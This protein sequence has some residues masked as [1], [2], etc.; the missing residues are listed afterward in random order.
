M[1]TSWRIDETYVRTKG[2]WKYLYRAV[3]KAGHTVDFLLTPQQ[4]RAAAAAFLRKA[5]GTQ[6]C[7]EKITIDRS[8]SNTAAI[9]QYNRI[10][11]TGIAIRQANISTIS[12]SKI[13][14][15]WSAR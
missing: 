13:I 5:I 4:D 1:G 7:P 11:N 2:E 6:G 9:Q 15:P 3:D 12:P 8:G 10:H 14:A